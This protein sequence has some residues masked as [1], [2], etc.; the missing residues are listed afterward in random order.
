LSA[1]RPTDVVRCVV[2]QVPN[3]S[4]SYY[5][6]RSQPPL[7]SGQVLDVWAARGARRD[8]PL[9]VEALPPL[10]RLHAY[11]TTGRQEGRRQH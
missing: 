5:T 6:N 7:L 3:G 4:R 8:D 11:W 1:K 2:P 9:L 10:L